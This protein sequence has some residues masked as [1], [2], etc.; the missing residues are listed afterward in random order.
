MIH[1]LDIDSH[2][3]DTANFG[4]F[5]NQFYRSLRLCSSKH[6]FVSELVHLHVLLFNKGC[7]C[8]RT[9]VL[10]RRKCFIYWSMLLVASQW[11]PSGELCFFFL[12]CSFTCYCI[13]RHLLLLISLFVLFGN[14]FTLSLSF[15]SQHLDSILVCGAFILHMKSIRK[16]W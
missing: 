7:N 8:I 13:P 11:L 14:P 6:L 10:L 12:L 15:A 9:R 3:L 4:V 1:I 2:L 16:W 5:N